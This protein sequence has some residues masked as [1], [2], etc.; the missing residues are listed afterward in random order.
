VARPVEFSKAEASLTKKSGVSWTRWRCALLSFLP[1]KPCWG[2]MTTVEN[3][4]ADVP[5][6][7]AWT[8]AEEILTNFRSFAARFFVTSHHFACCAADTIQSVAG[9]SD[10]SSRL[11]LGMHR[12][13]TRLSWFCVQPGVIRVLLQATWPIVFAANDSRVAI[14]GRSNIMLWSIVDGRLAR[15]SGRN[16]LRVHDTGT[17]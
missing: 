7:R 14:V 6:S 16:L 8:S 4:T 10:L 15:C 13:Y 12:T 3:A 1:S 17:W 9:G 11:L 2:I 5:F